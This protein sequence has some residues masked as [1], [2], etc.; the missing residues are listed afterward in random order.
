MPV[1]S[2][3]ANNNCAFMFSY[4]IHRNWDELQQILREM[5]D[6]VVD[7]FLEPKYNKLI[8]KD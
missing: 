4:F 5:I 1:T 6:A 7:E 3:F 8:A 2:L